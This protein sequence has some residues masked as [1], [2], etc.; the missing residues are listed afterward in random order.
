MKTEAGLTGRL[1]RD[2]RGARAAGAVLL[3]VVVAL[4]LFFAG[5]V[6]VLVG[7][8]GSVMA[9]RNLRVE[10]RAANLAVSLLSEIQMGQIEIA[11]AGPEEYD[12][13]DDEELANWSW[14]IITEDVEEQVDTGREIPLK[15]V[16]IVITYLPRGFV[17]RL[18]HLMPADGGQA[19]AGEGDEVGEP[20]TAWGAQ[21]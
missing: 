11:D 13:E 18:V 6:V 15:M 8:H 19:P 16:R 12:S 3:E 4:S 7:L 1:T 10:T 2:A 5:A 20:L 14:E 21:P 9:S 17:Y